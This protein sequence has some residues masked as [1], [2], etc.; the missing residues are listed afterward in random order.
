[1]LLLCRGKSTLSK[2]FDKIEFCVKSGLLDYDLSLEK[3]K[4]KKSNDI[5][6]VKMKS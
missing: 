2:Q 1:M 6:S 4:K 3:V 5:K